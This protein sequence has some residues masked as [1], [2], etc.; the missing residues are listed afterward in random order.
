[1]ASPYG[2]LQLNKYSLEESVGYSIE[3][4]ECGVLMNATGP[5]G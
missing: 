2:S 3:S 5:G 4:I 1:M